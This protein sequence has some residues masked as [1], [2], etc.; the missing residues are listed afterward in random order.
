LIQSDVNDGVASYQALDV[1]LNHHFTRRLSLL[2]S[3]TW[4]HAIDNVDPDIPGQNPNDPRFTGRQEI[5]SAIFDQRHRFVLSGFYMAPLKIDIG[6][7]STLA[8]GL[9]YNIVTGT[10]NSGDTGGTT[11]RPLLDGAVIP[12]NAGR[13]GPI[14][15]LSPFVERAFQLGSE[16]LR[17]KLRA[18]AFNVFN[19]ANFVGYSGTYGNG[20]TPPSG[21]GEP[22]PGITNQLPA[23]SLQFSARV[24]F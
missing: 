3:Y 21:L 4:S 24:S 23:R 1:N 13:G 11:D 17:L 12:R 14:Y 9:P 6:G 19:H 16:R 8:S 5:G 15:D 18:E 7:I 10:T 22:L 20:V 2:A